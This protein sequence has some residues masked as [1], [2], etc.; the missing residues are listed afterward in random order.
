V[1]RQL[2]YAHGGSVKYMSTTGDGHMSA[3]P[4]DL[5]DYRKPPV[6]ELALSVQFPPIQGF[7]DVHTGLYWETIRR[8]YPR[9]ESHPRL[10]GSID[11]PGPP[12]IVPVAFQFPFGTGQG[13]TW[14]IGEADDYLVQVQN[15]RFI[16]NWRHRKDPY[17]RFEAVRDLFRNNYQGFREVIAREELSP[18]VVQQV[19]VT[20]INWIS[21]LSMTE[22][23]VP[24]ASAT[25]PISSSP[26]EPETQTWTAQYLVSS[27][28]QSVERLYVQCQPALRQAPPEGTGIQFAL[29][30]RA[31]R[32]QGFADEEIVP[33]MESGRS[34]IVKA[35]TDLTTGDAQRVWDRI[36]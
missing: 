26:R 9:A 12:Q 23:L 2:E 31:A 34:I 7:Y 3:R 29:T 33:A 25:I 21:D 17:P 35:F 30:Y 8:N 4:V 16:Q 27:G 24:A 1:R 32:E 10:E 18:P 36:Q 5:P 11:S 15:T 14:L 22:F 20:Y 13:R 19:E 6:D 28:E